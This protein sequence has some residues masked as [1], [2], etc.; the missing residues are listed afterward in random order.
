M[1][2]LEQET[3]DLRKGCAAE[4]DVDV[5]LVI[6]L[7]KLYDPADVLLGKA[8]VGKVQPEPLARELYLP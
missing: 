7:K 3:H 8:A 1:L 4:P 5:Q 2:R 6:C